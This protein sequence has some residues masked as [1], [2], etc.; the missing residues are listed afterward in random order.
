[1]KFQL[2]IFISLLFFSSI[3]GSHAD[4]PDMNEDKNFRSKVIEAWLAGQSNLHYERDN[5]QLAFRITANRNDLDQYF[6]NRYSHYDY[7]PIFELLTEHAFYLFSHDEPQKRTHVVCMYKDYLL[8]K[9]RR[10]IPNSNLKESHNC[11]PF[12]LTLELIFDNKTYHTKNMSIQEEHKNADE[13]LHEMVLVH[14]RNYPI[15]PVITPKA[16]SII[17]SKEGS[18]SYSFTDDETTD[19]RPTLH[20]SM[21]QAVK[22]HEN[23]NW[24]N[25]DFALISRASRFKGKIW[26]GI[27][28]DIIIVGSHTISDND[29]IVVETNRLA[30]LQQINPTF[31]GKLI[32]F[33]KTKTSLRAAVQE[34]LDHMGAPHVIEN[35]VGGPVLIRGKNIDQP[36]YFKPLIDQGFVYTMH[37]NSIFFKIE[38]AL[39][40]L[41]TDVGFFHHEE[42]TSQEVLNTFS[43]TK[44]IH[45]LM[46]LKEAY[47]ILKNE[48]LLKT[49]NLDDNAREYLSTWYEKN[50]AWIKFISVEI[51]LGLHDQPHSL[52]TNTNLLK[53]AMKRRHA[54]DLL[55]Y[56]NQQIK[57][58]AIPIIA[59]EQFSP[60]IFCP[61]NIMYDDKRP[62]ISHVFLTLPYDDFVR[63]LKNIQAYYPN[64]DDLVVSSMVARLALMCQMPRF[65]FDEDELQNLDTPQEMRN[66]KEVQNLLAGESEEFPKVRKFMEF[67]HDMRGRI[68][69]LTW[70]LSEHS[71]HKPKQDMSRL[72]RTVFNLLK[73]YEQN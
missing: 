34:A 39:R 3:Q 27:S 58:L 20:F 48:L 26:G 47:F 4:I 52:F 8:S 5:N 40:N 72:Q 21:F 57:N 12:E 10:T 31:K 56:A 73:T 24:E 68:V 60:K 19:V 7:K 64:S 67:S 41:G 62:D 14:A 61:I 51:Q 15:G 28:Q 11:T 71:F 1:M 50:E 45:E 63:A 29:I 2:S 23:G 32:I 38:A 30:E 59:S 70:P 18:K 13:L 37:G 46:M 66:I 6:G 25:M 17:K 55:S 49:K 33:D 44:S 53:E 54:H 43:R 35:V 69:G 36:L 65:P 42:K 22:P 9:D 16:V